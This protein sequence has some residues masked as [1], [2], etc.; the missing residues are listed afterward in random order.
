MCQSSGA[1]RSRSGASF[2]NY[3]AERS[4][5]G[6]FSYEKRAGAESERPSDPSSIDAFIFRCIVCEAIR[7]QRI[8]QSSQFNNRRDKEVNI[9]L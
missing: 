3:W 9:S 7:D 5:S 2:E 8:K 1:E 6:A 4:W